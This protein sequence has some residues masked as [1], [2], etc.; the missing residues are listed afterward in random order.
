MKR[1]LIRSIVSA[2]TT[3]GLLAAC[4]ETVEVNIACPP[5]VEI[6]ITSG[7]VIFQ[8]GQTL[9]LSADLQKNPLE[10]S[11]EWFLIAGATNTTGES[12]ATGDTYTYTGEEAGFFR[13]ALTATNRDGTDSDTLTFQVT[14][15][16]PPSISSIDGDLTCIVGRPTTYTAT[17]D[18]NPLTPSYTW[19]VNGQT[20]S[21]DSICVLT[22]EQA[23][24]YVLTLTVNNE[25]GQDSE[26]IS[27]EAVNAFSTDDITH[28]TGE[29]ENISVLGI[30]WV[31]D[32]T[33]EHPAESNIH[34]LAWGYRWTADQQPTGADMLRSIV[35]NDSRL[36]VI[37]ADGQVTG[38]AY[39]ANNDGHISITN[40]TL[41]I[42][43]ANF[44]N[45]IWDSETPT[46]DG[47]YSNSS[48]DYWMGGSTNAYATYWT[49]AEG[50]TIPVAF[51]LSE[52]DMSERQLTNLSWDVWTYTYTDETQTSIAPRQALIQAAEANTSETDE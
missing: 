6:E 37:I 25:D 38:L 48:S 33:S 36:Y 32:T 34:F 7:Q 1:S 23:G 22:P 35:Q 31:T 30:Q 8:T 43:E 39:D 4:S 50:E 17:L 28:W 46:T 29:G 24:T 49:G 12:V 27:I 10:T 51:E 52:T 26:S 14:G 13:I 44:T 9:S 2:L 21:T 11:L 3:I 47:M 41:T 18:D 19:S 16:N 15:E 20:L 5:A 45:G 42:T 40:G